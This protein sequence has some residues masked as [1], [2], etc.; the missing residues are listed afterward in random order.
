MDQPYSRMADM[1]L[2]TQYYNVSDPTPYDDTGWTLGAL[3]NVKTVRVTDKAVLQAPM[4]LLTQDAKVAGSVTSASATT[5]YLINHNAENTLMTLRY[6]LKDLK[7]ATAEEP[8]EAGGQKFNAGTFI[9][10]SADNPG[11]L[12]GTLAAPVAESGLKAV[13]VEK[14]PELKTHMLAVPRI[15]ILHTWTNTQNEG[16][17][18]IEFDR[19]QIPYSY[20]SDQVVRNT[21]NL[22][23]KYDVI[24][25][26]PVGGSAQAIVSGLP[27]R[28]A[29]IPWKASEVTPNMGLAPDQADDIRGG[30]TLRGVLNLQKFVEDGGVFIPISNCTRLAI[31]YGLVS[32]IGIQD[33]RLLQARGSVYNATFADRRS[34]IAYGYTE[35]LPIYFNQTPLFQVAAAGGGPGAG[36]GGGGEG[37]GGGGAGASRPSGRGTITD[38]DIIQGMPLAEPAVP[39]RPGE[40]TDEQRLQQAFATPPELRPR[41]VLRFGSDEKTLLISGMLA[42]GSELASRPAVVDVPVGQGHVIMFAN[43]PMWR[44]QTQGSFFLIF[45]AALNFDHLSVGRDRAANP[46]TPAARPGEGN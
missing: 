17:F 2:D 22:K 43:N 24:I 1:M 4:T 34:P 7:I 9:I 32:G 42:G 12:K 35:T 27:M 13:A 45:N 11:D 8:F 16:W 29:P 38:P 3:R 6:R 15:A 28:G 46:G 33:P 19:L 20:I 14:L 37:G 41:V 21:A 31:D 40:L 36:G 30:M 44:H 39:R 25:F 26:P 5:A 18:R 10:K 23:E